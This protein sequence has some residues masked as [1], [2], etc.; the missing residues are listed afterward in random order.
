MHVYFEIWSLC[1]D[2]LPNLLGNRGD[3]VVLNFPSTIASLKLGFGVLLLFHI[4]GRL[5]FFPFFFFLTFLPEIPSEW[6]QA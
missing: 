3:F 6:N 2:L 1:L 5:P 4:V